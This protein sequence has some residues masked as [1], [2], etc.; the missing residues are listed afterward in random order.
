MI[1]G[2]PI[3]PRKRAF[4]AFARELQGHPALA[5]NRVIKTWR[6][7]DGRG[8]LAPPVADNMPVAQLRMMAGPVRRI[9]STRR[10]GGAATY[11]I[12]SEPTIGIELWTKGTDAGDAQDLGDLIHAV[13]APQDDQ[14]RKALQARLGA[15]GIRDW[16]LEREILPPGPEAFGESSVHAAG[17]Y[18]LT[19]I[20]NS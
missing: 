15:V 20:L 14:D 6:L 7:A 1:P 4:L 13:L 18:R 17:S 2:V 12:Q 19:L 10:V 5:N 11:A 3:G 16:H 9:A 8:S